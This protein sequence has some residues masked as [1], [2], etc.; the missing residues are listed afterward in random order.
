VPIPRPETNPEDAI[1]APKCLLG[2]A[3]GLGGGLAVIVALSAVDGT[4]RVTQ[5]AHVVVAVLLGWWVRGRSAAHQHSRA[6]ASVAPPAPVP[7]VATRPVR[8]A[9]RLLRR[10]RY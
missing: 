8:Q 6:D 1:L 3:I 9:S 10:W 5:G 4:L 7:P 2:I